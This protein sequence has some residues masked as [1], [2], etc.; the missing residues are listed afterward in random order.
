MLFSVTLRRSAAAIGAAALWVGLQTATEITITDVMQVRTYAEEVYTQMVAP[1]A[2][3]DGPSQDD[4]VA[5]AVAAAAPLMLGAA[6]VLVV[7]M[8]GRWER[9]LP[10][11][12]AAPPP[13]LLFP[14]RPA[15]LAVRAS[16]RPRACVVL[17]AVPLGSL[18]LAR[19]TG[20][21][22][23]RLV[24][25]GDLASPGPDESNRGRHCWCIA[26]CWR[27]F[28]GPSAPAWRC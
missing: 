21:D 19:G 11:R 25:G 4:M 7:V 20:G 22:A 12:D 28:R 5:R 27:R 8:A 26:C 9:N 3:A 2:S 14:L 10:P 1:D 18:V 16:R 23:A 17:L 15:A 13:P 24:G 6:A